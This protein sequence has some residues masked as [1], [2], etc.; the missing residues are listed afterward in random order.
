MWAEFRPE[1]SHI[2][3]FIVCISMLIFC[4]K[5]NSNISYTSRTNMCWKKAS[6]CT[7]LCDIFSLKT[8]S[9]ISI[10]AGKL[11]HLTEAGQDQVHFKFAYV[12]QRFALYCFWNKVSQSTQKYSYI[13]YF[14]FAAKKVGIHIKNFCILWCKTKGNF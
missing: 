7:I 4:E 8:S 5:T 1:Q 6:I 11:L 9:T 3:I 10:S 14:C 13:I 12:I 2:I